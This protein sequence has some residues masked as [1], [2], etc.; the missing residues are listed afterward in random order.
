MLT[1]DLRAKLVLISNDGGKTWV[2]VRQHYLSNHRT[3]GFLD[4][5]YQG[6]T[7]KTDDEPV[8]TEHRDAKL[9]E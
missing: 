8:F 1:K 3:N 5:S 7:F 9:D 4:E 6:A 2:C